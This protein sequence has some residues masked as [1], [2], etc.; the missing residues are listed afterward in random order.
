MIFPVIGNYFERIKLYFSIGNWLFQFGT[1]LLW[2]TIYVY[3]FPVFWLYEISS[4]TFN[5]ILNFVYHLFSL[6]L[7]LTSHIEFKCVFLLDNLIQIL[8]NYFTVNDT[9]LW[10]SHW[11]WS[12]PKG[13]EWKWLLS[14]HNKA[15]KCTNCRTNFRWQTVYNHFCWIDGAQ[16]SL[17]ADINVYQRKLNIFFFSRLVHFR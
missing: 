6:V 16:F 10:L 4:T 9:I 13:Y 17:K 14:N 8:Q 11:Q 2:Q 15:Q 1:K 3:Q 12:N 7:R 5:W